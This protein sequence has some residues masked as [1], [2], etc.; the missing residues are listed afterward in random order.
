MNNSQKGL[1]REKLFMSGQLT[2][3]DEL[4]IVAAML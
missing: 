4:P 2:D 1:Q 3:R